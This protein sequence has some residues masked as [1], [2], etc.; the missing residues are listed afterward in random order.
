MHFLVN[1]RLHGF[2]EHHAL[3]PRLKSF[4]VRRLVVLGNAQ[5]LLYDLELL[6]EKELALLLRY[7][8]VDLLE[9]ALDLA[10]RAVPAAVL[11]AVSFAS[12]ALLIRRGEVE[13]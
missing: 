4:R 7:L 5:F 12:V 11:L 1:A 9:Q 6:L 3:E 8:L 13:A 2:R 10:P